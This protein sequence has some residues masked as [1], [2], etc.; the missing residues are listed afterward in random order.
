[1]RTKTRTTVNL[2]PGMVIKTVASD[3]TETLLPATY[4]VVASNTKTTP[5]AE[6]C[7]KFTDGTHIMT[8]LTWEYSVARGKAARNA[9]KQRAALIPS[10]ALADALNLLSAYTAGAVT[11]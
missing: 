8:A 2:K 7:I 3:S 6:R 1:M 10:F 9:A 4:R 5:Y 11:A